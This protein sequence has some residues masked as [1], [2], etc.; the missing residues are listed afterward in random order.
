[1][2]GGGGCRGRGRGVWGVRRGG[3]GGGGR[4]KRSKKGEEGI[5]VIGVNR[6]YAGREG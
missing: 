4:R 6:C 1:M 5:G 2:R 3:I